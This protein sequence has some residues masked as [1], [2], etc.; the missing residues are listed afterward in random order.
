MEVLQ[1]FMVSANFNSVLHTEEEGATTFETKDDRSE[2]F[3][4]NIIVLFRRLETSTV[5]A[6][7]V[8]AISEFLGDDCSKNKSRGISFKDEMACPIGGTKDGGGGANLF[9]DKKGILFMGRP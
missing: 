5:K 3:I 2:F 8:D 1:V 9:Q 7:G 4:V 6:N